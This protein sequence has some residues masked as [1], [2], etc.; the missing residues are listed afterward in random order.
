MERKKHE[1]THDIP[2]LLA[3][4]KLEAN[5]WQQTSATKQAPELFTLQVGAALEL[6]RGVLGNVSLYAH[7]KKGVVFNYFALNH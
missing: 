6:E 3:V 2:K 4:I 1:V 7:F 5:Y